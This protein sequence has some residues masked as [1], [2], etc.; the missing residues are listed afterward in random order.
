MSKTLILASSSPSRKMLLERFKCSFLSVTPNVDE[1]PL[2]NE[3]PKNLVERLA[4]EKAQVV[5]Q[6]YSN[7]L[8]IGADQV[9]VLGDSILCKPLNLEDAFNQL[10]LLSGKR[11]RYLIGL[12]LLD[13]ENNQIQITVETYDVVFNKLT[14]SMIQHYLANESVLGCA[15]SFKVE[16]FGIALV[17]Q[18]EGDDYTALIGLPLIKLR[19]MLENFQFKVV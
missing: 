9:G 15:G 1:T 13:S 18:L 14:P 3:S 8:I 17:N 2:K 10:T 19:Q 6:Q 4:L 7:A 16:G 11:L 5:A 12:C